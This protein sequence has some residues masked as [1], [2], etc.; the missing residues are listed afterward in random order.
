MG[1][2]HVNAAQK[3]KQIILLLESINII[4]LGYNERVIALRDLKQRIVENIQS[5]RGRIDQINKKLNIRSDIR[6]CANFVEKNRYDVS[7]SD[8]IKFE[9]ILQKERD[10]KTDSNNAF[11]ASK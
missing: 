6:E 5:D 7:K 2:Q 1:S 11:G 10:D 9:C 4:K 8:L 3:R